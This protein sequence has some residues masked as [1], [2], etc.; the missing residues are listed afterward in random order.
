[1]VPNIR[2]VVLFPGRSKMSS[3]LTVAP[4]PLGVRRVTSVETSLMAPPTSIQTKSGTSPAKGS[5]W[6]GIDAAT[7]RARHERDGDSHGFLRGCGV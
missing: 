6:A 2:A 4:I 3:M 5:A 1:M 7:A